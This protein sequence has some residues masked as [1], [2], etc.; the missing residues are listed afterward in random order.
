MPFVLQSRQSGRNAP[1]GKIRV[2]SSGVGRPRASGAAASKQD[3]RQALLGAAAELF[4]AAGYTA[5]TTRAIAESAGLR[6]ASLYYHF[7]AKED[8]LAALLAETVR[9]SLL[10][11]P[12]RVIV[13][14]LPGR[15]CPA[16]AVPVTGGQYTA[17]LR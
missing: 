1:S 10:A 9:P 16:A 11:L 5:T 4:T 3:A 13:V 8:I 17:Q 2:V 14:T 12:V 15:P 6:Q 7:P